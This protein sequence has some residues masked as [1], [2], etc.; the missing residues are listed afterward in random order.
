M[1]LEPT[2]YNVDPMDVNG[3]N[4]GD[5][6]KAIY[7]LWKA[8]A[9]ALYNLDEDNG[10]LGTDYMSKIGT[11]LNTAMANFHTPPSGGTT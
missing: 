8:L 3:V 10:T 11:D 1:A 9:A 7:N 5:V 2:Y 6:M 4:Q